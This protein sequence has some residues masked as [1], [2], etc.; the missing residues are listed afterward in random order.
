MSTCELFDDKSKI[1]ECKAKS[2][3][4]YSIV[5]NIMDLNVFY[6]QEDYEV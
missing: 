4:K 6:Q 1:V 2:R 3:K 5:L